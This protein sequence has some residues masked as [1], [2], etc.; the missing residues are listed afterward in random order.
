MKRFTPV[1]LL[2]ILLFL[3]L[4]CNET[5]LKPTAIAPAKNLYWGDLHN[6]NA[7]GYARGSLERTYEIAESHLDFFCFTPHTYWHDMPV[8]P[9]NKHMKWVNGFKVTAANWEKVKRLAN[10]YYKPGRFVSFIGFEWHSNSDGDMH[11][12]YPGSDGD[13]QYIADVKELQKI[14]KQKNA[15]L[16]PHH[17]A[18]KHLWRGQNW[19]SLDTSVS[20]VLEIFSEHG[21]AESDRAPNRY[22]RHSMGG[23]YTVNTLQWLLNQ[24]VQIGVV[25]STDD[26][27]GYP[28]AYGEGLIAV[29]ADTLTRESVM[30]AIKARRTYGV[31]KDRIELDFRLNGHYM[32]ESIPYTPKRS[33]YVNVKGKDVIDRVEILRNNQVIYRDHPIDR[34]PG[35]DRWSQPV[36][37]R[38]EFGWGPWG[39]LNMA[40]ICDWDFEVGVEGGTIQS[41]TP[42]FQAG[43]YAE[44]RRN[45]LNLVDEKTCRVVSYTS[46]IQAFEERATNAIV[47]EIQGDPE[48]KVTVNLKSP[49]NI[50]IVKSLE[51]LSGSSDVFFTGPFSSESMLLHRL[52]FAD[53]YQTEFKF[54]DNVK[55]DETQWYYARVT[56]TNGSLAWSSPIWMVSE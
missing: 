36:L 44:D 25:A 55:T 39:D 45:T 19:N 52:V 56:Q 37:C 1:I 18:Y 9:Q 30:E 7:I 2:A 26:H 6:H 8:M 12:V 42:C 28:G 38:I 17:P 32:G 27:L 40:R 13:L 35:A 16:V 3:T 43:P 23:R 41:A 24:G 21:N 11:M 54:T 10:E 5:D 48:T 4:S 15:I 29:Y 50:A 33:V 51:E 46:R 14:A 47:L 49:K 53:N 34:I 31:S 20:P 22:I